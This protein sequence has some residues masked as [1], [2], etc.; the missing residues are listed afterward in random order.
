MRHAIALLLV[1]AVAVAAPVPKAKAKRPDAEVFVGEWD[2]VSTELNGEPQVTHAK[3]WKIDADL[4]MKS[5]HPRGRELDW[6]LKID[7]AKAPKEIDVSDYKGI[8]EIDGD[9]IRIAYTV[10]GDRPTAFDPQQDV[11]IEV[12]RRAKK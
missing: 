1:A 11:V 5:V 6:A 4:K 12:I 10:G 8:Y 7:P 3:V 9:E 2:V